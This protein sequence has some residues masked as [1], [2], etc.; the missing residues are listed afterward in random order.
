MVTTTIKYDLN[1][2]PETIA[3]NLVQTARIANINLGNGNICK[4]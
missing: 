2:N 3:E 4:E 1:E